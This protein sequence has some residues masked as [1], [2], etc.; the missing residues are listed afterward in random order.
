MAAALDQRRELPAS[1]AKLVS[2]SASSTI[3]RPLRRAR[4][5]GGDELAQFRPDPR[6]GPERDRAPALVGEQRL[7]AAQAGEGRDH[8][9][10]EMRGVD[11]DGVERA[12]ERD[13]P[14][15]RAQRR[16]R[17][18]P[19]RAGLMRRTGENERRAARVFVR[20]RRRAAAARPA[21]GP[22]N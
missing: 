4:Q 16:P 10:G 8:D 2:A 12:C 5:R 3:V 13:D 21:T 9:R 19:R 7:E 17:G 1:P 11:R 15:A 20:A 22:A 6:P 14:G 18:K